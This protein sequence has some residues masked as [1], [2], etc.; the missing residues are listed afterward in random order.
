[1]RQTLSVLSSGSGFTEMK[2]DNSVLRSESKNPELRPKTICRLELGCEV[3]GDELSG[4]E[5]KID[6]DH[7]VLGWS[8]TAAV[9]ASL[10]QRRPSS[11]SSLVVCG[12]V[13]VK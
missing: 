4:L 12:L 5:S 1:M 11:I 2:G 9:K 7:A 3:A 10:R 13:L 6:R 8:F